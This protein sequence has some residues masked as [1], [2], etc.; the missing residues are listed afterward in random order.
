VFVGNIDLARGT[1]WA[2]D[3]AAG[4]TIVGGTVP[5][6][7]RRLPMIVQP[8]GFVAAA[9]DGTHAYGV[10]EASDWAYRWNIRSRVADSLRLTH[11]QR[12]GARPDHIEALVQDPSKAQALAFQWSSP[13]L[14]APISR[15][16]SAVLFYDPTLKGA[17]FEGPSFLQ[18]VDWSAKRS[19]AEVRLP[20]PD[21]VV[22]RFAVVGDTLV[23][24]VQRAGPD[25]DVETWVVRWLLPGNGC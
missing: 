12:R 8:F 14:T 19:C 20:V 25:S 5:T 22:P 9:R 3:G 16:R 24:V 15:D 13:L 2:E 4:E 1:S 23:A 6:I 18:V 10:F 21:D 11:R 7:Y 17:V